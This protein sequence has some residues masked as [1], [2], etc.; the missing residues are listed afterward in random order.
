MTLRRNETADILYLGDCEVGYR[1]E[2]MIVES[3]L[4]P[5]WVMESIED[6]Y[7]GNE[8]IGRWQRLMEGG[9]WN[10]LAAKFTVDKQQ[11]GKINST[12]DLGGSGKCNIMPNIRS[13]KWRI[14]KRLDGAQDFELSEKALRMDEE[15][16][17][18]SDP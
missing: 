1:L 5:D 3:G 9:R 10:E 17:G 6:Y 11:L 14:F 15:D 4:D 2:R 7:K 12:I 13:S 18:S 16:E 8:H